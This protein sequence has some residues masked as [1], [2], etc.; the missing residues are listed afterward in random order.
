MFL[1]TPDFLQRISIKALCISKLLLKKTKRL[2]SIANRFLT[3]GNRNSKIIFSSPK[4]LHQISVADPGID[5]RGGAPIF[6]KIIHT[7]AGTSML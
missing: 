1:K 2:S 5:R 3:K 6:Q 4:S 7:R